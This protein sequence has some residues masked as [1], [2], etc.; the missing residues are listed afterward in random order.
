MKQ[1]I[2]DLANEKFKPLEKQ[3]QG[4][5]NVGVD[6][7]RGFRFIFDT[8]DVRKCRNLCSNCLL[9]LLLKDEKKGV[10]SAGLYLA[11]PSDKEL[12]GPQRYLNCKTLDQYKNCYV[13]FLIKKTKNKKEIREELILIKNF[14]IIFSKGNKN[15]QSLEQ[16]FKKSIIKKAIRESENRKRKI[17][18]KIAKEVGLNF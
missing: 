6:D 13:N 11:S 2:L 15:L 12:F 7:W 10:F 17:I 8:K 1:K 5:I 18:K 16:N 9:Y 14:R 4:F 3:Y